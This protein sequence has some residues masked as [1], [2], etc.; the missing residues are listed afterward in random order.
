MVAI[1][2]LLIIWV[3]RPENLAELTSKF[4]LKAAIT[5]SFV[6]ILKLILFPFKNA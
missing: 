2:F 1:P 3:P 6:L 4:T 5:A